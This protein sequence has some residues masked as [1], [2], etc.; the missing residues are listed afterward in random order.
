MKNQTSFAYLEAVG[1]SKV[2]MAYAEHF[3]SE[4]ILEEGFNHNSGY[5]YIA[6]ESGVSIAS[7]LGGDVMYIVYDDNL[8][9]ELFIESFE[10]YEQYINK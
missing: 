2:W 7:L 3:A 1:K 8:D 6:L 4:E 5:V 9:E 10:Y